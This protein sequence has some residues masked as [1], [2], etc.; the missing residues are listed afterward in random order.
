MSSNAYS[1][2]TDEYIFNIIKIDSV[3]ISIIAI[4]K[5][6]MKIINEVIHFIKS[7]NFEN[8]FT[9]SLFFNTLKQ[10]QNI[11]S[12][13]DDRII[14]NYTAIE[15]E[16]DDKIN[17]KTIKFENATII[18]GFLK[19]KR[20]VETDLEAKTRIENMMT[21][22]DNK[23]KELEDKI[24]TN[25]DIEMIIK[26]K[27]ERIKYLEEK[28][29]TNIEEEMITIEEKMKMIEKEEADKELSKKYILVNGKLVDIEECRKRGY[30]TKI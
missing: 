26:E 5:M 12:I 30:Y 24:K 18:N 10:N 14:F 22:K 9:I 27:D 1:Y 23:I 21:E 28:M 4:N 3:C 8:Q 16:K 11:M 20:Y 15:P 17:L 19:Y 7:E 13:M 29:K 2:S 6:N 25:E